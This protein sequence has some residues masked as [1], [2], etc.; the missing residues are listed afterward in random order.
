MA[1]KW[2]DAARYADNGSFQF[3]E[4][5]TSGFGG[6]GWSRP[7]EECLGPVHLSRWRGDLLPDS[8]IE[9]KVA[10]GFNHNHLNNG[11]RAVPRA[12]SSSS[13]TISASPTTN[14]L[15]LTVASLNA[16]ITNTIR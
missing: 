9:Q 13:S 16:T 2:L 10:S 6:I 3:D 4:R 15:G 12:T 14:W 1:L 7:L 8:T 5:P 11:E